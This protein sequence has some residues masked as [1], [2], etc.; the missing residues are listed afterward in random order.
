MHGKLVG[1]RAV[2][3]FPIFIEFKIKI[4]IRMQNAGSPACGLWVVKKNW[5]ERSTAFTLNQTNITSHS[6]VFAL[7]QEMRLIVSRAA[8]LMNGEEVFEHDTL[9]KLQGA[10]VKDDILAH[11][12]IEKL[13]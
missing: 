8:V 3:C 2:N 13:F 10:M 11:I 4:H 1:T 6:D 5:Y 7:R 9:K 12:Y